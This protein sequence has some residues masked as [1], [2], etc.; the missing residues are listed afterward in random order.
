MGDLEGK[1]ASSQVDGPT[2]AFLKWRCGSAGGIPH[3]FQVSAT[4]DYFERDNMTWSSNHRAN[5]VRYGGRTTGGTDRLARGT[6]SP[7]TNV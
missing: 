1:E 5:K 2:G 7:R 6:F 3:C 4:G